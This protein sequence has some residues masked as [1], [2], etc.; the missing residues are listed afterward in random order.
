MDSTELTSYS[1]TSAPH[2]AELSTAVSAAYSRIVGSSVAEV[3]TKGLA[4]GGADIIS[5]DTALLMQTILVGVISGVIGFF[6][7]VVNTVDICVFLRQVSVSP[8]QCPSIA[9]CRAFLTFLGALGTRGGERYDWGPMYNGVVEG[10]IEGLGTMGWWK[11]VTD[12]VTISLMGLAIA[13]LGSDVAMVWLSV[14]FNPMLRFSEDISFDSVDIQYTTAC[15]PHICLA[16]ITSWI[17]A[18]ITFE[19]CL[20]VVLPLKVR[21]IIT[22]GRTTGVIVTIYFAMFLSV[23]PVYYATSFGPTFK[24]KINRTVIGLLYI[25]GGPGLIKVS[26][27]VAL[28]TQVSSFVIVIACTATLT[29]SLMTKAKWR[30]EAGNVNAA[31]GSKSASMDRDQKVVQ[32]VT[33]ISVIFLLCFTP[34]VFHLLTELF[35][36]QYNVSGQLRNSYIICWSFMKTFEALNSCLNIFVYYSMSSKFRT[37]FLS[38]F[39]GKGDT[40]MIKTKLT[41]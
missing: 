40:D 21:S 37:V 39:F 15:W 26:N 14:C 8:V 19:R 9:V 38:M 33:F 28:F 35:H 16:R 13:E 12:S 3:T 6:G 31:T 41:N 32:M 1:N 7:A 22:P 25:P 20:C 10:M 24:P 23:S 5:D 17:T 18:Y 4:G 30:M 36:P 11:G 29:Q 34:C 27:T 2:Q